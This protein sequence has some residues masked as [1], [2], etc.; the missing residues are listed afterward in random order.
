M[1]SAA[2]GTAP[3]APTGIG[4]FFN[5]FVIGLTAFLTVVDLFATQAILPALALHYE[6]SPAQMGVAANASTL[7]MAV[8]GVVAAL[9]SSRINRRYGVMLS[10]LLL[11]VPTALLAHAPDLVTFS[12]LRILQ[13]VLMSTAFTLTLAHLGERCTAAA[14]A[15]AFAAYVTGNV[16]SNLFGRIISATSVSAFGLEWNFYLFAGLN[17]LGGLLVYATLSSSKPLP[18]HE[19]FVG[20]AFTTLRAHLANPRLRLGFGIGFCILFAFIGVFTYVNFVLVA[21]PLSLG[22][23]SIALVY[24]IFAPS[25]VTTPLAGRI[26][27]RVGA[28]RGLWLGLGVAIAGL[29]LLA[30]GHLVP[31]LGGMV[32]VASGT[33]F[34]QAVATGFV[35]LSAEADRGAASGLY[36]AFYFTGGLVGGAVLGFAFDRAGW[37]VTLWGGGAS[38]GL[39]MLL[40]ARI[41][42]A[43]ARKP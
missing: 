35:S 29:P 22:T 2:T 42:R 20:S 12:A 14:S 30:T 3:D 39:A 34:A 43:A 7:G 32:L 16:A 36:L 40:A 33:F 4:Q 26:V 23:A 19:S 31:V 13:G 38:L 25:I 9:F 28:K 8:A 37:P 27:A 1:H 17:I 6:V 5:L 21:P 10:L 15:S 24:F 11:S 18:G 41:P